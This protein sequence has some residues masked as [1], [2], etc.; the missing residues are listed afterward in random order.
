[1]KKIILF[2][3]FLLFAGGLLAQFTVTGK[4]TD[5]TGQTAI[6]AAVLVKGTTLGTVTDINGDYQITCPGTS[7]TLVFSLLGYGDIEKP[8]TSS[9]SKVDVQMNTKS[10]ELDEVIVTG[11]ATSVKRSNLA[12]SVD[13][14]SAKQLTE[15][16]TQQ[17]MDQALYGKFKGADIRAN[18]GSPGGGMSIRLRGITAVVGSKQ[19]L[20]IIDGVYINNS[21]TSLGTNVVSAAAGGGNASTNQDDA[22]NRIADIDPE[23]IES[24]EV[25][26]GSSAAAIY[27]A[28]AANG[29]VIITTKKGKSGKTKLNFSQTLGFNK[30]ISQLGT[31][32]W[33]REKVVD[34]YGESA[35]LLYD[36]NGI[37]DYEDELYGGTGFLRTSRISAS[38]GSD[39]TQFFLGATLKDEDG[40]VTNTGYAKESVRLNLNH[41]LN[42]WIDFSFTSNYVTSEADR[43]FFNNSNSNT[44]VGYALA[45]TPPW[46]DLHADENGNYPSGSAGSNVLETV[47]KVV[48]RENIDRFIMGL[49]MNMFLHRTDK[50]VLKFVLSGGV[51]NFTLR[52]SA[53]FPR[54]LTYFQDGNPLLG[55]SVSGTAINSDKNL[56][57]IL[58]HTY[59][60]DNG[61]T[62]RSQAGAA[63]LSFDYEL[64]RSTSNDL[65]GSQT[66]PSQ[67]A[68]QNTS[69]NKQQTVDFGFFAQEEINWKDRI[70]GTLGIRADKSTNNSDLDEFFFFPKANVAFNIH[71]FENTMDKEGTLSSLKVRVAYGEAGTFAPFGAKFTNFTN[72]LIDGQGSLVSPGTRG[73]PSIGPQRNKELEFGLDIGLFGNKV[74]LDVTRYQRETVDFLYQASIPQS[75]GYVNQFV[76]AGD[77]QNSGWEIGLSATPVSTDNFSWGTNVLFWKNVSEVTRLNIDQTTQDGFA[78]SL[79]TFL[80][81][82]GSSITQIV[83]T[84]NPADCETGDCGDLDPDG[85]GLQVYGNMEPDFNMSWT[86]T[87][88]YKNFDFSMLWHWKKGGQGINLSTLLY[89]LAQTTWD[90]DDTDLDPSG[91]LTNGEYRVNN[92]LAGSPKGFIENT[93]YLRMREIG[94]YYRIPKSVFNDKLGM[95]VGLSARNAL[96]FFDYNSYDPEV[97][98]FGNDVLGNAVEVTPFPS[99]KQYFFHITAT[100]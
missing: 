90:Y 33:T 55:A 32:D 10:T 86:N 98:N 50:S 72:T 99:A 14:I 19:P 49:N 70:I 73:N 63:Q 92:F 23:D 7:A 44:T 68:V 87:L 65:I 79:G 74:I 39:K 43:G 46:E 82:E 89:D 96:N 27:G 16:T 4:V 52:T 38:G 12:N 83:G 40:I 21:S 30:A 93:G 47:D 13:Y 8:V 41:K 64:V 6:G 67:G 20:Y 62:F 94:V 36:Q 17:T 53:I 61:I 35:A 100:F 31:R 71:N 29:V 84:F 66:N 5:D 80:I 45:F 77:L 95:K 9:S 51:D 88:S 24:I 1:M 26:K 34:S 69:Y 56:T 76:N 91:E 18:S 85:D 22:S 97:S 81:Q 59:Y 57:G 78:S 28:R 11:L 25:L 42:D 15:V 75:S 37:F 58:L 48:N 60:A 2:H 54:S 3:V